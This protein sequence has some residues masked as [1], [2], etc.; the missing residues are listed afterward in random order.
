[1]CSLPLVPQPRKSR[2]TQPTKKL[3]FRIKIKIKFLQDHSSTSREGFPRLPWKSCWGLKPLRSDIR[4]YFLRCP[5][6]GFR[7]SLPW[8][9]CPNPTFTLGDA[10]CPW[11]A[12]VP[13]GTRPCFQ[14]SRV[15]LYQ[16]SVPECCSPI[17][18]AWLVF[19]CQKLTSNPYKKAQQCRTALRGLPPAQT[20]RPPAAPR[21]EFANSVFHDLPETSQIC[22]PLP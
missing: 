8:P 15:E 20:S 5:D 14:R 22:Q 4:F 18:K 3:L 21:R 16:N 12:A 19:V 1:M 7:F 17:G 6:S 10:G 9:A 2:V 13:H 11:L